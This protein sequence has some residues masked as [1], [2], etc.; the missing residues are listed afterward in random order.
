[1]HL[2]IRYL[3]IAAYGAKQQSN[4]MAQAGTSGIPFDR[5]GS[6]N[7]MVARDGRKVGKA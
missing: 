1:M 3:A 5:F 6:G 2:L 4:K 7:R